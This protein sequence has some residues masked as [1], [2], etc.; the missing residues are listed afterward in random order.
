MLAALAGLAAFWS[1]EPSVVPV[2]ELASRSNDPEIKAVV[3]TRR[4]TGRLSVAMTAL[5]L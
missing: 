1:E 3:T 4:G 5:D 2:L